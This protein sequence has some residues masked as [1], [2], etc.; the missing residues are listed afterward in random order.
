MGAC[1]ERRSMP[2]PARGTPALPSTAEKRY[3]SHLRR[4]WRVVQQTILLGMEPLIRLWPKAERLDPQTFVILDQERSVYPAGRRDYPRR[5]PDL[6]IFSPPPR[7]PRIWDLSDADLLRLWPNIDPDDVRQYAPWAT[8]REQVIR[9]AFPSGSSIR[10]FDIES[11]VRAAIAAEKAMVRM[12]PAQVEIVEN[13]RA[14]DAFRPRYVPE[15]L[16]PFIF[17]ATGAPLA[18]PQPQGLN[19]AA[20]RAQFAWIDLVIQDTLGPMRL[21]PIM[22]EIAKG[23]DSVA[24]RELQRLIPIDVRE[25]PGTQALINAW[26]EANVNLI[27]SGL[28]APD[29]QLRPSL[30]S[31]VSSVVEQAHRSGLRV[32]ALAGELIERF[33][34]S[35]SRA[36]LIARDQV[37]KLNAQ[38][39]RQKQQDA[40]IT[41]YIWRTSGDRRVRERH[42]ELNNTRQAWANPPEVAPGRHEHPGGDYQCRCRARPV[43]PD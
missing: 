14:R 28:R 26:R 16:R 29:V 8:S 32:E 27:E 42:A 3:V 34:V 22:D 19:A 15:S 18:V 1:I 37:L 20:I 6:G 12:R 35:E 9:I 39:H 7:S 11:K 4:V 13:I 24:I 38:I 5:P 2:K 21:W 43:I 41:H 33:G 40:G 31:D 36:E 10:E 30:L 25:T 17:T 23:V